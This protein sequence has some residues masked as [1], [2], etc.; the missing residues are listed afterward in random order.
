MDMGAPVTWGVFYTEVLRVI[1]V[2]ATKPVSAVS[3]WSH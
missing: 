3:V 1:L 2:L